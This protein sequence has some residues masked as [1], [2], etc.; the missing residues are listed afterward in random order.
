M[1]FTGWISVALVVFCILAAGVIILLTP[2]TNKTN[3]EMRQA[4]TY[5]LL[6]PV[7]GLFAIWVY[8]PLMQWLF[9]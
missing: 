2:F 5:M 8:M 1:S 6:V 9:W 4:V 3:K 7:I